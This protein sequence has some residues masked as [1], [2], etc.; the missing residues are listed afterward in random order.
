MLLDVY[1]VCRGFVGGNVQPVV[2]VVLVHRNRKLLFGQP[3]ILIRHPDIPQDIGV[4]CSGHQLAARQLGV[5]IVGPD[6][7]QFE[8]TCRAV[9]VHLKVVVIAFS[10]SGK[11]ARLERHTFGFSGQLV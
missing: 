11:V 3:V 7:D 8:F 9:V 2:P 1:R 4:A 10:Q 5:V 6:G